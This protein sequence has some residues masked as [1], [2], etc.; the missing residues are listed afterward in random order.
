MNILVYTEAT[1]VATHISAAMPSVI[2][3]TTTTTVVIT[4]VSNDHVDINFS[5][6]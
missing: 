2:T 4:T 6:I 3:S 1:L 5:L